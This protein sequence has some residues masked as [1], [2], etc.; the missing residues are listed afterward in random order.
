VWLTTTTRIAPIMPTVSS[1]RLTQAGYALLAAALL[2]RLV[3][4]YFHPLSHRLYSDMANYA[5]LAEDLRLGIWKPT[6]FFQP[7]GFPYIMYSF[8]STTST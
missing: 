4:V 7:I 2:V 8:K 5:N 3:S 6:H 1:R